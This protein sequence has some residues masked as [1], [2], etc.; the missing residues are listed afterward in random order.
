M[1]ALT[2]EGGQT[3]PTAATAA[4]VAVP[5]F[6]RESLQLTCFI[7]IL[8]ARFILLVLTIGKDYV[9]QTKHHVQG[10]PGCPAHARAQ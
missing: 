1:S 6:F 5:K 7:P 8:T 3:R 10:A 2:G 4:W 9:V